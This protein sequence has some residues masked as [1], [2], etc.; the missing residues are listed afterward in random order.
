MFKNLLFAGLIAASIVGSLIASAAQIDEVSAQATSTQVH[1]RS[2][3]IDGLDIFYREAGPKD[4][5]VI[6]LLHGFPTSSHMYRE[7]IPR[8]ADH[9]RV[10]APDYPGLGQCSAPPNT[11]F[12]YTFDNL[13]KSVDGLMQSLDIS[14]YPRSLSN[15]IY[16]ALR[17]TFS[18]PAI[19]R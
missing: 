9:Y 13:A 5:P 6:L 18:T 7:L 11:V 12:N 3:K 14:R 2:A 19:L 8:L 10:I 17:Y 1:Y 16:L 4:A 15:T